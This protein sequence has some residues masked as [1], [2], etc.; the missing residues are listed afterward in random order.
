MS[1]SRADVA[2][3]NGVGGTAPYIILHNKVYDV[4]DWLHEHPGGNAILLENAGTDATNAFEDQGHSKVA[5][6]ERKKYEIGELV[7]EDWTLWTRVFKSVDTQQVETVEFC[8]S[9]KEHEQTP[10]PKKWEELKGQYNLQ[11][12]V[13]TVRT[14]MTGEECNAESLS[15][16]K[17]PVRAKF[18]A[19]TAK[20]SGMLSK[21]V[22]A[23]LIV[24][25]IRQTLNSA[26]IPSVTYSKA[27]RH[28]HLLMAA[29]I[30]SSIWSVQAANRPENQAKKQEWIEFHKQSGVL[31]LLALAARIWLRLNSAVPPRFPGPKALQQLEGISHKAFYALL[32]LLPTSGIAY[33]YIGGTGVPLLGGKSNPS[34]DD[35]QTAQKAIDFHR[36]VGRLFE[37]VWL[38]FHLGVEAYHYGNGRGVVRRISPFL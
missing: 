28:V 34:K 30:T 9:Q 33:G 3:Y 20:G 6:E 35:V 12:G 5:V 8:Y 11:D 1:F 23:A 31:M 21:V 14:I 37:Y 26:P 19:G 22:G 4:T 17:F 18:V 25:Y 16:D 27:L 13:L 29:G 32:L 7:P 2:K 36:L 15:E 10:F 38:P 24:V